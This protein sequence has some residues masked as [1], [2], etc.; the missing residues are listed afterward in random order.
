MTARRHGP[1]PFY[2]PDPAVRFDDQLAFMDRPLPRPRTGPSLSVS[3][4]RCRR[5]WCGEWIQTT[6]TRCR[7][8]GHPAG[9]GN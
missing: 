6:A 4:V 1:I 8:C 9:P 2:S 7:T 3:L 5:I